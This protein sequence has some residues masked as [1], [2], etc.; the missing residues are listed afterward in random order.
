[1]ARLKTFLLIPLFLLLASCAKDNRNETNKKDNESNI[2]LDNIDYSKF[3][4]EWYSGDSSNYSYEDTF[5]KGGYILEIA[6]INQ[7]YIKGNTASISMPPSNRFDE[8]EFEG[9]L[10]DNK[11]SFDFIDG[12]GNKGNAT[13]TVLKDKIEIKI[14]NVE[15]SDNNSSG[16]SYSEDVIFKTKRH[17]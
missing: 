1:M 17:N 15:I 3:I 10:T 7:N 14:N 4:G 2:Q 6:E 13:I 8:I 12:F 11:L 9:K 5:E 16:M